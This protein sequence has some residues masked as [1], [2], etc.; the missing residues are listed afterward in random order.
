MRQKREFTWG[1][2]LSD[3]FTVEGRPGWEMR[4]KEAEHRKGG[5]S[6]LHFIYFWSDLV[7]CSSAMTWPLWLVHPHLSW[8]I[9]VPSLPL[10][11]RPLGWPGLCRRH[12]GGTHASPSLSIV[13][14]IERGSTSFTTSENCRQLHSSGQ[15][16]YA[17][18]SGCCLLQ[19]Y[20]KNVLKMFKCGRDF[21]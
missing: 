6:A 19:F 16:V 13:L 4:C 7:S 14:G 1:Q 15:H 3:V 9:L 12:P 18:K 20:F 5:Q 17:L 11:P 2:R 21:Q 10:C 8:C